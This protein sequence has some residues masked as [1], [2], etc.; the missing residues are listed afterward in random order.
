[1]GDTTIASQIAAMAEISMKTTVST[2]LI[3]LAKSRKSEIEVNVIRLVS[4]MV[5]S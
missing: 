3:L 2:V 1:M 4:I 5:V